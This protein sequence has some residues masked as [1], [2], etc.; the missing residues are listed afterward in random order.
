MLDS[1]IFALKELH[2][3]L[4]TDGDIPSAMKTTKGLKKWMKNPQF[5]NNKKYFVAYHPKLL[6]RTQV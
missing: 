3:Y 4:H 1:L 2:Q 5:A 6:A